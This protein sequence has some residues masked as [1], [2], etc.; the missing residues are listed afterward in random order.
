[1]VKPMVCQLRPASPTVLTKGPGQMSELASTGTVMFWVLNSLASCK[2]L[3][4]RAET[5]TASGF[6][7]LI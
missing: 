5:S 1:M 2:A 3:G 6:K 4:P 7:P